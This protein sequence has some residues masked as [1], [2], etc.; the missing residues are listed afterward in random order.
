MNREEA[1]NELAEFLFEEFPLKK[2][3]DTIDEWFLSGYE[4]DDEDIKD[5]PP[6]LRMMIC[7]GKEPNNINDS[8]YD[9]IIL[10]SI[11]G[12]LYGVLNEY[13]QN[14]LAEYGVISGTING[15]PENLSVCPCC[16]YHALSES[17]AYDICPVCFW[18]DDGARNDNDYSGPNHLT[19]GEGKRNFNDFGACDKKSLLHIDKDGPLKYRKL[20]T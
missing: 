15:E 3:K 20:N 16:H 4:E 8:L 18:E 11:K 14:K 12:D 9:P 7:E 10:Q 6:N 2:R 13:I 17:G 19:L 5:F 1:K